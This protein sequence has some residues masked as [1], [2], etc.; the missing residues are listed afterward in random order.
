M[1]IQE[2]F[3]KPVDRPIEGVIKAD[4]DRFLQTEVEEY[5]V[6][7]D[8]TRGIG[9]FTDAYLNDAGANGVW[10]SGYFGSGKSHLLKMLRM[11]L[12]NA[13]LPNGARPADVLLPKFEDEIVRGD[14][15]RAIKVPSRNILFNIDQK[16]EAIGGDQSSPV[17][18]VFVKVFNE[19]R[20]YFGRQGHIAQFERE[21]DERGQ[22]DA[23]QQAYARDTGRAW[24]KDLPVLEA[25]WN[26][27]F[28]QVYAGF[29][30][31][32][33]EECLQ[34]F[35]RLRENYRVSIESFAQD[36]RDY[37]LRQSP[38]FRLN[39][40][41]D[42]VGQFIGQSSRLMLNLQTIAETLGTVCQGRAWVFVTS[43][44]ELQTLIGEM[45][46]AAGSDFSKIQGRFKTRITL[47]S[48]DVREVIQK[49]LLRKREDEPDALTDIWDREKD[50]LHTLF[51]FGDG[52]REW[53]R[54]AGSREFCDFYPL[55]P[56][57]F[58]LF[59]EAIQQLS[60]HNAFTGRFASVGERSMLAVFQEVVKVLQH[61]DVGRLA[62]FD[63]LFDGISASLRGDI[64]TSVR[65]AGQQL[66]N[67]LAVR[68]LKA[69]FLLKW[70]KAFKP[71]ARN[72]AILLIDRPDV[73]IQQ[74]ELAVREALNL[75][76]A[77]SYLQ[78]NGDLYEFLTEIEKDIEV[79]IK[80][81]EVD[82][83]R[84]ADLLK[85][86]LFADVLRE[87]KL[88]NDA[89]GQDYPYA[90]RL[91]DQLLGR[92]EQISVN[93]ITPDHP[94][95]A[96]A[97]L[98]AAR[99]AGRPELLVVL[100]A[101]AR[102]LDECQQ[103]LRTEKY[104]KQNLTGKPDDA[105][106]DILNVRAQQ[107]SAR[108][109]ALGSRAAEL[110]RSAPYFLNG[111]RLAYLG[112][113]DPRQRFMKAGQD[114]IA[115]AFPRLK[116]L[117]GNPDEAALTRAL[118]QP[119]D[120]LGA[121]TR[122][123]EAE[124]DVLT[125][126]TRNGND[127]KRNT[128]D[129]IVRQYELRPYGW[130]AMATLLQL[131]RL[132]RMGR[133]ELRA[134]DL[135]DAR[136]AAEAL[137]NPR[138]R[139][140]VRVRLQ[141]QFNAGQVTALKQFHQEFFSRD[142]AGSD[143][144]SV[145]SETQTA[146]AAEVRELQALLAQTGRYPFLNQL[147]PVREQIE[148]IAGRDYSAL[149]ND[150]PAFGDALLDARENLIAPLKA[151]MNGAQRQTYD[152]VVAFFREEQANFADLPADDL[153]AVKAA[154]E[155]QTPFRGGTLPQAKAAMTRLRAQI[156]AQ[157][158]DE[159]RAGLAVIDAQAEKLKALPEFA[160]LD[161]AQQAQVLRAGEQARNDVAGARF[162]STARDRLRRYLDGDYPNQLALLMRLSA[163][164]PATD[165]TADAPAAPAPQFIL[166][167]GLLRAAHAG[168]D[169]LTTEADVDAW[170][171]A[172]REAALAE[173]KRGNRI[174]L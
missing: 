52:A 39:F 117:R 137:K 107:N 157:L 24:Q 28:A 98:L 3:I 50:N 77:Q 159:Q 118:L 40:F 90:R 116:A 147:Q 67:P 108:R 16:S 36:V 164:P 122:L 115:H 172:L 25:L 71:T 74:H 38:G 138:Q 97:D 70:S 168:R 93:I 73:D 49:R 75:L 140:N 142:N 18:E 131:A 33:Y 111:S 149:L 47:S 66:G 44:G 23:F 160:M 10:I 170:L 59:Q 152:D 86:I 127:G 6:T 101:D 21:L 124:E 167:A 125:Y 5:V 43:Q 148:G 136:A 106:R 54:W 171:R 62:T 128:V 105:R 166:A 96:Q 126:V 12:E 95:H 144:R 34:V 37:I 114:L 76:D 46:S 153:A 60:I 58:E 133:I 139:G 104:L 158:T 163:P 17:L 53:K 84:L 65:Q 165:N 29:S 151:F 100:P 145:A 26:E 20:G 48:A 19:F 113:G 27:S 57:Q 91:D 87:P 119:D 83:P 32:S 121:Q 2:L 79:E 80:N 161:A 55:V 132:F 81:T 68:I 88:R 169:V 64:Q 134:P 109:T 22:F 72:I 41:V 173:L 102:L 112:E 15:L 156:A 31:Q 61:D 69:L 92:D 11:T 7:R 150:L 56:Y 30:S 8:V 143:P 123:T 82:A 174:S 135:L 155:S 146:L 110:M 78:R 130:P 129:E 141:A 1:K 154:V 13:P 89:N 99:N 120:L 85:N 162:V 45:K 4:D 94:D 103:F 42:E 14:L 9:A 35:S 63:L 51:R